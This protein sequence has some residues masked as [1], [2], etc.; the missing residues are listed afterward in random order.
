[1]VERLPSTRMA[2]PFLNWLVDI[3]PETPLRNVSSQRSNAPQTGADAAILSHRLAI[4]HQLSACPQKTRIERPSR[5]STPRH[6]PRMYRLAARY[7]EAPIPATVASTTGETTET[8][9]Q[10]SSLAWTFERCT[11]T[12]GTDN[13]SRASCSA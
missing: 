7:P 2:L 10:P 1:M 9:L 12:F 6:R 8:R 13:V 3:M 11:S 5:G 4:S